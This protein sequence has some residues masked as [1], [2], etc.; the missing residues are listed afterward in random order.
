MLEFVN[1]THGEI[2]NHANGLE[3][4]TGLKIPVLGIARA[5][6]TVTVNGIEAK[7]CG[8]SFSAEITL[9][10]QF[11]SI[12]AIASGN[13]GTSSRSIQVAYDRNSFKRINFCIDDNIYTFN[14]LAK[15]Q[16]KS[17]F[18]HFY[19]K[20]LKELHDRWDLRLTLN[21]FMKDL[22]DGFTLKDFPASYKEEFK[23]NSDWLK[24]AF[25]AYAEFPDRIYQNA[26]AEVLLHDYESVNHEICRF[27]GEESLITPSNIHWCMVKT[28]ALPELRKRGVHF[29]GGLF[30]EGQTRIGE[31]KSRGITCDAGYF[32]SEETSLFIQQKKLWHDFRYGITMGLENAILNLE[33]L[34][35][36]EQKFTF[37]F[38]ESGGEVLHMLTHE[39]YC[40]PFYTE[41]LPDHFERMELM[42]RMAKEAGYRFVFFNEG[43]LGNCNLPSFSIT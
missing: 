19:L 22:R 3:T 13:R 35:E 9:K 25:H 7:R 41:Y 27:A 14:E 11:E 20:K 39:Q 15:T 12:Q 2:L 23:D 29:L 43:F 1:L 17:L 4:A 28:S 34:P 10:N 6:D 42:A 31:A 30:A 24:L 21:L 18:D 33:E 40:F 37:L 8:E 16:P 36:L 5:E 38:G 26:D 32:E